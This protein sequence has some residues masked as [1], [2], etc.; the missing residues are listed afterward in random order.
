MIYTQSRH[1]IYPKEDYHHFRQENASANSSLISVLALATVAMV[2]LTLAGHFG[3]FAVSSAGQIGCYVVTGSAGLA[4]IV[5]I[6]SRCIGCSKS[7]DS[8]KMVVQHC[9]CKLA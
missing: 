7:Q 9:F 1:E 3:A 4:L 6:A 8:S 5:A 2:G